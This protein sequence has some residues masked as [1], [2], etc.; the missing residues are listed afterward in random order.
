MRRYELVLIVGPQVADEEV[1]PTF[2]G[3]IRQPVEAR[4]GA[5]EKVDHWGRR[6]LAYPIQK[7]LEG[8]YVVAH[9]QLD[10]PQVKELEQ[11]LKI[12]EEVLRYLFV[13]LDEPEAPQPEAPEREADAPK[14]DAPEPEAP[15][16]EAEAPKVEEPDAAEVGAPA[17]TE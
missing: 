9:L 15:E 7:Q 13:R 11:A 5:V 4:G 3:L 8:S 14:A 12:S 2:D 6:K 10:P 17:G 16:P 1:P